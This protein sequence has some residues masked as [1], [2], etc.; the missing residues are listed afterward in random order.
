MEANRLKRIYLAIDLKSF[1]AS[2]ECHQR[3]L[4]PLDTN[5]IVADE[6]RTDKT[7]CLAVFP[8]LKSWGIPGRPR[9]FEVKQF[10]QR[11]NNERRKKILGHHFGGSSTS[12]TALLN[13]QALKLEY[14]IAKPQMKLYEKISAKIYGVYL[15]Y[16]AAEDIHVYSIDEAFID[17]TSYLTLYH[18]KASDL[19]EKIIADI[20]Q[21]TGITA[22]VGI[23]TN[24]YLAKVAMD[25]VAKH[26]SPTKSGIKIAKL[27]E[28]HYRQL[29]W[30]H[31]P[32]TDFWRVGKGYAKRLAKL[33][34]HTMGE[35]AAC[36]VG[37]LS[38]K[39]NKGLLYREFGVNAEIL[40]DHAWG[41][42]D[43]TIADI[44]NYH[45]K[46]HCL[47]VGQ[48][49]NEPYSY[50]EGLMIIKEMSQELALKLATTYQITDQ[51]TLSIH[52]DSKT[53]NFVDNIDEIEIDRFG[54]IRPKS[55]HGRIRLKQ[56]TNLENELKE[57]LLYLFNEI[58]EPKYLLR[59]VTL[60]AQHLKDCHEK[61]L[62]YE[63]GNLFCDFQDDET[64]A[65]QMTLQQ[66]TLAIQERFGK[67]ALFRGTDLQDKA[68]TLRRNQQ[69]GGHLA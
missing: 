37:S 40:I 27:D 38:D 24:L 65:K 32:I 11:F 36:S 56:Y 52:Y 14:V 17:I 61:V 34:I 69:I 45:P 8:A 22:T 47:C 20:Y 53:L 5:L 18:C 23:G 51:V 15:K 68:M 29:L 13:N 59:R 31:Q 41:F 48:L 35:V 7:I 50:S 62:N 42:E 30:N 1:Y 57:K 4:D 46:N 25:I 19:A 64:L 26:M 67:N 63:Q 66:T 16:I 21:E 12:R 49:L 43:L 60:T 6:S 9:L 44:N 33:G 10:A 28:K 55:V 58:V 39:Y 3:G 2:V 54:R